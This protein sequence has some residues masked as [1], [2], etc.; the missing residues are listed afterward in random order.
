MLPNRRILEELVTGWSMRPLSVGG[1]AAAIAAMKQAV[2]ARDPFVLV[3]LDAMMPGM[4]GF[5]AAEKIR[6]QPELPKAAIMMLSSADS[7]GDAAR[8]RAVGIQNYLRKP[9]ASPELYGAIT[10][11]LNEQAASAAVSAAV[12]AS[13]ANRQR[14]SHSVLLAEDNAVNRCVAAGLLKKRGYLVEAVENGKQA[15]A[16]LACERFD[17]I[18]MDVQMPEMDGFE[19]TDAIRRKECATGAH[20]PVVAMTAHAM[21]GDRERCLQAGMDDYVSKPIEPLQLFATLEKFLPRD[22]VRDADGSEGAINNGPTTCEAPTACEK[23][24]AGES[25]DT[26]EALDVP[27]LRARVESD[28]DLLEEM[29]KLFFSRSP[30]LLAEIETA[31]RQRDCQ[32]VS[33]AAHCLKGALLNMCAGPCSHAAIKLEQ[34]GRKGDLA[35]V[36]E[37]FQTLRAELQRLLSELTDVEKEIDVERDRRTGSQ[38][39]RALTQTTG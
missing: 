33:R 22:D 30:A 32:T 12:Q 36:N 14:H 20:L 38:S 17:L 35:Q 39:A 28:L 10:V 11:A 4:D 29:I 37:S 24:P 31:V 18:L 7:G 26:E 3:L 27:A 21:Q 8:C 34:A 19:T 23:S 5:A 15:L 13:K 16:A 25:A 2:A 9:V 6:A 1:G